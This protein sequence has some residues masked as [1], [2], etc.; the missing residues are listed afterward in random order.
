MKESQC[1][2]LSLLYFLSAFKQDTVK[3]IPAVSPL[4]HWMHKKPE[5]T[6]LFKL[7]DFNTL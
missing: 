7:L 4:P 6:V 1:G 3:G 2:V 5:K